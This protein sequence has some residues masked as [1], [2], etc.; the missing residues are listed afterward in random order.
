MPSGNTEPARLSLL[1]VILMLAPS[2]LSFSA[3]SLDQDREVKSPEGELGVPMEEDP[4]RGWASSGIGIGEAL[5]FNRKATYVP[6]SDW[7]QVTGEKVMSGWHVL[8][9]EYPLPS[10]WWGE[11]EEGGLDCQTFVSPQGFHCNVP[12]LP[13]GTLMDMDVI[14][15][16]RF[17]P[18]DKLAPDLLPLVR[19]D[20]ETGA[21]MQGDDFVV[22]VLLAGSGHDG[23]LLAGPV[24]VKDISAG[25]FAEVVAD[26]KGIEWLANQDFVEWL[27]PDYPTYLDN[28]PASD[29][30]N[31]DWVTDPAQHGG[32]VAGYLTGSGIIVGVGDS[33]LD[34]AEECN[35]VTDCNI[36]NAAIDADF[37]GRIAYVESFYGENYNSPCTADDGPNDYNGHGTHVVGSVLGSGT[38]SESGA[39]H[40]GM[41][42]GAQLYMQATQCGSN[43]CPGPVTGIFDACGGL[44]QPSDLQND[45]FQPAYDFGA[46]VHTNSWGTGPDKMAGCPLTS[47]HNYYSIETLKIDQAAYSMDDLTILFAMGNDGRDSNSN[48]EIDLSRM[49]RQATAKNILSIGASENFRPGLGPIWG[50]YGYPASPI[51]IDNANNDPEGLA[52]FSNRGPTNDG[53]I[54]PDISAPGT[55]IVSV[56]SS[57]SDYPYEDNWG[58]GD[59]YCVKSGT[60]MAT[61]IT[62]G[63]TALILE[64]LNNLGYSD[65]FTNSNDPASAMVKAILVAGAHDMDGQYDTFCPSCGSGDGKNGAK[66][67]APNNHEGWGRVDLQGSVES[68]FL[69]GIQIT[70]GES[71]SIRLTLPVGLPEVRVVLS[72]N[73][74]DSNS[75]LG[76]KQLVNDLDIILKDP[77]GTPVSYSNDDLNNLVGI[78][79]ENPSGGE[80]ELL[81]NGVNVPHAQTYYVASSTGN[82]EDMRHPVADAHNVAGF[83]AGSIFTESSLSTDGDNICGILDDSVTYCWGVGSF[84]QIGDG[85][86]VERSSMTEVGL[87]SGRTGVSISTGEQHSCAILDDASL[88]CWGRNSYGQLGDG[89]TNP[90]SSTPVSV[91]LSGVPVQVSSGKWHTCAILDDASLECWGRNNHGQLGDGSSS[92]SSNTPVSVD[93]SGKKVLAVSVGDSHT[94]AVLDDWSLS[95]W[96]SNSDGQLGIGSTPSSSTSPVTVDVG[97]GAESVAVSAGGAHT[98]VLLSDTSLKCWGANGNGQLGYGD[99]N[100]LNDASSVGVV[101]SSVIAIDVGSSHS[102]AIDSSNGLHC[103]GDG[104]GGQVG[105][106]STTS[107]ITSPQSIDLGQVLGAIAVTAGSSFTCVTATNDLPRCWGGTLGNSPAEFGLDRRWTYMKSAERDLDGDSSLN[108]FEVGVAGDTDGDGFPSAQDTFPNNPTKAVNCNPGSY[109][110]FTCNQASPGYFVSGFGNT[111]MTPAR[112]GHYVSSTGAIGDS[113]CDEG[114]FQSETGKTSCDPALPGYYVGSTGQS[115]GTP[116]PGGTFNPDEGMTDVSACDGAQAGYSVPVLTQVS[117]G[118]YHTCTILDDGSISCWGKND[119]GQLGDGTRLARG[120][121]A[122]VLLPLGRSATALSAGSYHTCAVLDDGSTKCWGANSFGQLGDGSTEESI[123]P[124]NAD[125]GPGSTAL[126]VTTGESHTCALLDDGSIKCWGENTNGQLGDGTT[127]NRQAP[128]SVDLGGAQAIAIAAGSYHTCAVMSNRSVMCWGNNWHGQLGDGTQVDKLSPE[129]IPIPSNSSAVTLDSGAFHTC[130]GMNDGSMFCWGYNAFGQIGNGNSQSTSTP[131]AV[132][133]FESQAPT[134]VSMGLF[135]SCALFDDGNLSCW[136]GNSEGQIGDGTQDDQS[137]PSPVST[138]I[139]KKVLSISTGQRHTCAILDDAS[140]ECW[141]FNSEGQLGDGGVT[142]TS[143]PTNVVLGHG[144]SAEIACLPG[145][146]QPDSFQTSCILANRGYSVPLPGSLD[147]IGCTKGEYSGLRGQES[148]TPAAIGFYVDQDLAA[149]QTQ[150]PEHQSTLQTGSNTFD[151]CR[152]DFD[153]DQ[154]PDD[155]DPDDDNDGVEDRDDFDPLDPNVSIDSDGDN[156]PDSLDSDDDNDGFDDIEDLFPN[157]Q[158]EWKDDDGDGVGDNS[159]PD[160][161]GDGRDDIFD[162]FPTNPEEWSDYDGDGVGDNEDPD[163]DNDE[164][165]DYDVQL[166]AGASGQLHLTSSEGEILTR[167]CWMGPDAFPFD[168]N[169][170][171]DT[172]G[173]SIGNNGDLDDDGDGFL[174]SEDAFE[175]DPTE[176][177]DADMDTFGDNIDVFDDDPTEWFDSDE[178]EI[179]N[180]A[181]ECPYEQGLNSSYEN[182]AHLN[183][184][185]EWGCPIREEADGDGDGVADQFDI[186]PETLPA[187]VVD[188]NGCRLATAELQEGEGVDTDGDGDADDFDHDDDNDGICDGKFEKDPVFKLKNGARYE[189][190]ASEAPAEIAEMLTAGCSMGPD[191]KIGADGDGKFSKDK[192]RPFGNNSWA[193][194]S[195][196]ALFVSMMGYRLIGWKKRKISKLKSKRIRIG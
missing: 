48:G 90:S 129:L 19:G 177:L 133:L 96:G 72:W 151:L 194:I 103:W 166:V 162:V 54:K 65:I 130:V 152:P 4:S 84:G 181:D 172:D 183:A 153:G 77:S 52:A 47:C 86:G 7:Q 119:N 187:E 141:G 23:D 176:W 94:C 182:W 149:S 99:A 134:Q 170:S 193:I 88:K 179:G 34:N 190:P 105:D 89:T 125:L 123:F 51:S 146:Y 36:Q 109:G 115:A 156:I 59:D 85:W 111:V 139:G 120:T 160:D 5:L 113:E 142:S 3:V 38:N 112:A 21:N 16:F 158:A 69:D 82:L 97:T 150:C 175:L 41:A 101:L 2:L 18:T 30:V 169:E 24:E 114:E 22:N 63:S 83:Q 29:I 12:D 75:P 174:D 76:L 61:P 66:E 184:T 107:A 58:I 188:A 186:C 32:S 20:I 104:S 143:T 157:N 87:D 31:V 164:V 191:G 27:E 180:N 53:R 121:P 196:S 13:A 131:S 118:S 15:S 39:N 140:L 98:C 173:D 6:L 25:R 64:H 55:F 45:F 189:G 195:V 93:F 155:L 100:G 126:A 80:W 154:I 95:C 57:D 17:D 81:V 161:D 79:V 110:R 102:C 37:Y 28:G 132:V 8:G 185:N 44:Y 1:L 192:T 73:D 35:G 137:V 165:C 128:V 9:H 163:D 68:T 74:H 168:S 178:D 14:G 62:A 60:S 49:N 106:G 50:G 138:P 122:K 145:T 116:C 78:T 70:T 43:T 171:L 167:G 46:R 42:P 10:D 117:T 124:R 144:S 92:P 56:C 108:I 136:G 148:C 40:A 26:E 33:G 71:H 135:H 159:D 127:T 147:Q 67:T 11:L 91:A